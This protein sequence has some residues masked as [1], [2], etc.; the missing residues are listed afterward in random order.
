VTPP[1]GAARPR[2]RVV[3]VVAVGSDG[4]I[5]KEGRIPW[6]VPG[7]LRLFKEATLGTA[8]VMGRRTWD[9]LPRR[10]LPD[11][12]NIV[13]TRTPREF[14]ARNP[15]AIAA[16]SVEEALDVAAARGASVASVIGGEEICRLAFPLADEL[17]LTFVPYEGGGDARFPEWDPS[18]W[19]EVAREAIGPATRVRYVRRGGKAPPAASA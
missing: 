2:P 10:P 17:L 15:G 3:F 19:E 16:G 8:L 14:G 18:E 11:R 6:H 5:G 7:E 1:G 12:D 4:T 9:S 13:V